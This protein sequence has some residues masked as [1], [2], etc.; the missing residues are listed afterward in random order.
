[1]HSLLNSHESPYRFN[2]V[3]GKFIGLAKRY[4]VTPETLPSAALAKFCKHL[5]HVLN[6]LSA[7]PLKDADR[8]DVWLDGICRSTKKRERDLCFL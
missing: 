3:T 2:P 5:P 8:S 1:L 4:G 7:H 6:L